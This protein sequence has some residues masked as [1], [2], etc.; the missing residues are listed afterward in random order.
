M[1]IAQESAEYIC[2]ARFDEYPE[3]FEQNRSR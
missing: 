2:G 3:D 1:S